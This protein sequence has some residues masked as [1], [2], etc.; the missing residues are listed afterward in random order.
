MYDT[1]CDI[2]CESIV[3]NY[4][5]WLLIFHLQSFLWQDF[6]AKHLLKSKVD[7]LKYTFNFT[8]ITATMA[9]DEC[10]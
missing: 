7:D 5:V 9:M 4:N 1:T 2:I 6:D 8:D 10:H 3:C